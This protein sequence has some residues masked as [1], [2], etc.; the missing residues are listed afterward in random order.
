MFECLE[1]SETN[2]EGVVEPSYNKSTRAYANC[3]NHI[4]KIRGE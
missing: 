1:I 2:Y 3:A 4:S